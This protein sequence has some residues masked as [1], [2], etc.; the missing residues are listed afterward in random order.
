MTKHCKNKKVCIY[1]VGKEWCHV[2]CQNIFVKVGENY[3]KW[4]WG[5]S[6]V[7][8]KFIEQEIET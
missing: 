2:S 3:F 1:L 7:F 6:L 5:N 8:W 4:T